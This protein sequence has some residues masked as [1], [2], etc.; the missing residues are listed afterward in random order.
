MKLSRLS[1]LRTLSVI[2]A[3][4]FGALALW[5]AAPLAGTLIGNAASA[6]YKDNANVDRQVTSNVVTTLIQ[7]VYGFTLVNNRTATVAPGGQV[8]FPHTLTNTGNGPDTYRISVANRTGDNFDLT[9]LRVYADVNQDGIPD[10]TV[11]LAGGAVLLPLGPGGTYHFVVVGTAPGSATGGQSVAIDVVATPTAVGQTPATNLDSATVTAN[12]VIAV[13]KSI[14]RSSGPSPAD[15]TASNADPLTYTLTYTNTG[16][17]AASALTI[18]DVIPTDFIYVAGSGSWSGSGTALTDAAGETASGITYDF[19]VTAANRVTAVIAAVNPGSSGTLTFRIRV[20]PGVVAET[21]NNTAL[22][23]YDPGTGTPTSDVPT[24][25]VPYTITQSAGV[26]LGANAATQGEV[27]PGTDVA[28]P[29]LNGIISTASPGATLTF[30]NRVYNKGNGTD[31]FDLA[32]L[33]GN[34]FPAGTT[35]LF[36]KSDGNTPLVDSNGNGTPDT[37]PL[38]AAGT[39]DVVVKAVLPTNVTAGVS[40][41]DVTVQATSTVDSTQKNTTIDRLLAVTALSVDLTNDTPAPGAGNGTGT[42]DPAT[43]IRTNTPVSPGQTTIFTLVATNTSATTPDTYDL[44]YGA[45][46]NLTTTLPTGWTVVIKDSNGQVVTNTGII[47]PGASK[48]FTAEVTPPASSTPAITDVYF[49]ILSPTTGAGDRI[50]DAVEVVAIRALE[51]TPNNTGQT[52]PGGTVVYTHTVKNNSNVVEGAVPASGGAG[53]SVVALGLANTLPGWNAITYYDAN[54]DGAL[55]ATD[56]VVTDLSFTSAGTAGLSPGESVRLF[57]KVFAPAGA[58]PLAAN[59]TT[60]TAT[61]TNGSGAG[62]YTTSVPPAVNTTDTTTIVLGDLSITKSQVLDANCDGA[63]TAYAT[64]TIPAAAPGGCVKYQIVVTNT[65][66]APSTNIV[67][68]DVVPS[69]TAY[70]ATPAAAVIGGSAPAADVTA[71]PNV[72]FTIGTLAPGAT[73]TCTFAVKINQ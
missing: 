52:Y 9:S 41:R 42:F 68:Y 22:Y 7:Q 65:G 33:A 63:E 21:V 29:G 35:F 38:A 55:D 16:N 47:L 11:D 37:G 1:P 45:D 71:L 25:T 64:A 31:T 59:V 5:A 54:G 53:G 10:D 51:I 43:R 56:P 49:K 19:N 12:A 66:T 30:V 57:T 39:Y 14:S 6:T 67:V 23:R 48:T 26:W 40:N 72:K 73:A 20:T 70:S 36:Y 44:T 18:T 24:N 46:Q 60:L 17:S 50:R 2:F 15:T 28:F 27:S 3:V 34:T 4:S 61:V 13:T 62:G 58:P 32:I 8:S 69:Y